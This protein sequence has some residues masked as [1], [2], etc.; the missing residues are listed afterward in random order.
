MLRPPQVAS[1][2]RHNLVRT[3]EGTVFAWGRGTTG[4]LGVGAIGCSGR[5]ILLRALELG[6]KVIVSISCGAEHS[7]LL[8]QVPPPAPNHLKGL[9]RELMYGCRKRRCLLSAAPRG[10]S[11]DLTMQTTCPF[12]FECPS[13]ARAAR[14]LRGASS[15]AHTTR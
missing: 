9:R 15:V 12:P 8:T 10:G 14:S 4:C 13:E 11:S 2:G 1:G 3:K 5:P 7:A 6:G